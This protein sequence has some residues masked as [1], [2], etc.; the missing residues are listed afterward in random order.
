MGNLANYLEVS[1]ILAEDE[2]GSND[3]ALGAALFND[4]Y[5]D[6]LGAW[7]YF[8]DASFGQA[9]WLER[10]VHCSRPGNR[11]PWVDSG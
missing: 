10:G 6:K 1:N 5:G 8:R 2:G 7:A 4:D 11:L 3:Y 9:P